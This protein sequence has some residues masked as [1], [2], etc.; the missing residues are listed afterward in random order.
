MLDVGIGRGEGRG[1]QS[2][3]TTDV[4]LVLFHRDAGREGYFSYFLVL[5]FLT[6]FFIKK[7]IAALILNVQVCYS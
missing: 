4:Q 6:L 5:F 3:K 2:F 7:V 1:H